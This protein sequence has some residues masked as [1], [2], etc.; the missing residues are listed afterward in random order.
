MLK[1][2]YFFVDE[3]NRSP[4]EE[5][6]QDLT[7]KEDAKIRAYI[8][9]LKEYGHDLRRPVADYLGEGIYELRPGAHRVFY[10]FFMKDSVVL[11]HML[12]KKTDRIPLSDLD[13]CVKRK[14]ETEALRNIKES[15]I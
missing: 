2:V 6:M 4:V 5:A 3:H 12:R 9:I 14:K 13:L 8:R 7:E 10:F 11:L 15:G 1:H